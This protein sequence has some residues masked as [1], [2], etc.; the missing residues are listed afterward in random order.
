VLDSEGLARLSRGHPEIAQHIKA[1]ARERVR[2]NEKSAR[3]CAPRTTRHRKK[4]DE[5]EA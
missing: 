3:G 1:V 2:E 5:A 4:V